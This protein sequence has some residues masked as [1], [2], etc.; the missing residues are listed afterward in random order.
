MVGS[1]AAILPFGDY[2]SDITKSGEVYYRILSTNESTTNFQSFISSNFAIP[3]Y[4][5]EQ[6]VV[7][8]FNEVS[9]YGSLD[10]SIVSH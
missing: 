5:P 10:Y 4:E 2:N 6:V 3:N 7:I 9:E 1:G 8:T